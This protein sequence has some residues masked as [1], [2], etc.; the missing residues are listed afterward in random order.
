MDKR[1]F[2]KTSSVLIT[3]G[4]ASHLMGDQEP[5]TNWSGNYNYH[6][7]QVLFP[8][9]VKEVQELVRSSA[10]LKALGARHSFDGIA[11]TTGDQISLAHFQQMEIDRKSHTV[12]VGAGVKY[13]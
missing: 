3:G 13:G 8:K 5:R 4:I 7:K 9:D 12:T 2:L 10:K 1:E 6:A 11:D